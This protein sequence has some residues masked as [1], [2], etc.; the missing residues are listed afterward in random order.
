MRSNGLASMALSIRTANQNSADL[1]QSVI[2]EVLK[3]LH[4][5]MRSHW[6]SAIWGQ[7]MFFLKKQS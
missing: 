2:K 5:S 6:E 4:A 7:K 1:I 3:M